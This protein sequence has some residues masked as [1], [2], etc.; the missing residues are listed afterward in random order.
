MIGR[1]WGCTGTSLAPP[2]TSLT[3]SALYWL[4]RGT[5][6]RP[7][8]LKEGKPRSISAAPDPCFHRQ[9]DC[10]CASHHLLLLLLGLATRSPFEKVSGREYDL[11][12]RP[13]SQCSANLMLTSDANLLFAS[14]PA[15]AL[16]SSTSTT[17][18]SSP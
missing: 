16:V 15:L 6:P 17:T 9:C 14:R 18:W 12:V 11:A 8:H 7:E 2:T 13:Q 4:L 10:R 5:V 1:E 3:S